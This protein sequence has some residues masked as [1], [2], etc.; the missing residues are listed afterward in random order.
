MTRGKSLRSSRHDDFEEP[1]AARHSDVSKILNMYSDRGG[2]SAQARAQ[3]FAPPC[4]SCPCLCDGAGVPAAPSSTTFSFSHWIKSA[5][6]RTVE[7][8][9]AAALA[10]APS[11]QTLKKADGPGGGRDAHLY[12]FLVGN[13]GEV[14]GILQKRPCDRTRAELLRLV[15]ILSGLPFFASMDLVLQTE[16]CRILQWRQYPEKTML[17]PGTSLFIIASGRVVVTVEEDE[18]DGEELSLLLRPGCI[19]G[20]DALLLMRPSKRPASYRCTAKE[21]AVFVITQPDFAAALEYIKTRDIADKIA[22]MQEN[23]LL[24]SWSPSH[25]RTLASFMPLVELPQDTVIIKEGTRP[26]AL[27]LV[28]S[29]ACRV[30]KRIEAPRPGAPPSA[31]GIAP[32]A[33]IGRPRPSGP[34]RPHTSLTS[35]KVRPSTAPASH[36]KRSDWSA[37]E[38]G[39]GQDASCRTATTLHRGPTLQGVQGR[40]SEPAPS[41]VRR[42]WEDKA[43]TLQRSKSTNSTLRQVALPQAATAAACPP[44]AV[45]SLKAEGSALGVAKLQRS[46]SYRDD[47]EAPCR[48]RG[49]L[50]VDTGNGL[51]FTSPNGRVASLDSPSGGADS[52]G[53]AS[54]DGPRS[55]VPCG[56]CCTCGRRGKYR[57]V[58]IGMLHVGDHFGEIGLLYDCPNSASIVAASAVTLFALSRTDFAT[59]IVRSPAL[60]DWLRWCKRYP[61]YADLQQAVARSQHWTDYKVGRGA[62]D[63]R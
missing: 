14:K 31:I 22:V 19:I 9:M 25:L 43:P 50:V 63:R 24:C 28:K 34:N 5:H 61:S 49:Q 36:S 51:P 13:P 27:Y 11:W 37:T 26:E 52:M 41:S 4:S 12:S 57:V 15:N 2:V 59:F 46:V 60:A 42:A 21:T 39:P 47:R 18:H 55:P 3:H 7:D 17:D 29:G 35:G 1:F 16:L 40:T 54:G 6:A 33:T 8:R 48:R 44:P 30:L 23:P 32:E 45:S 58:D 62:L 56:I 53:S 10:S 20:D 38:S